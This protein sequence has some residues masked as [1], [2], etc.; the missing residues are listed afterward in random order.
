MK[1]NNMT[2]AKPDRN[3]GAR[4]DFEDY[5]KTPDEW[6]FNTVGCLFIAFVVIFL[7]CLIL[8][9]FVWAIF[10]LWMWQYHETMRH[11]FQLSG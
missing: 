1:E 4:P 2:K 10:H 5:C 9:P 8:Y 3:V 7:I 6:V 11:L